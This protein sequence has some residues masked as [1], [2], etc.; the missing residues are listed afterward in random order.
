MLQALVGARTWDASPAL[1]PGIGG[2]LTNRRNC[3]EK[4][5]RSD[6]LHERH[7]NHAPAG[8]HIEALGGIPA[9]KAADR[10]CSAKAERDD[11]D[12]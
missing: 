5:H 7:G 10:A 11:E 1:G 12:C 8:A 3:S 9:T 6:E 4:E 2:I